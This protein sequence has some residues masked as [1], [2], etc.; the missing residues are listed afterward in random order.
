MRLAV[1]GFGLS[2]SV[3]HG[4]LITACPD[5]ELSAIVTGN[6][7][8]QQ[9]AR[10]SYPDVPV[11]PTIDELLQR[12]DEFDVLVVATTNALHVPLSIQA[13]D[14][15]LH[16]I[17]E[18][19]MAGTRAEAESIFEHADSVGRQVHVFQNRR[20]DSDFLT[21]QRILAAGE[22]GRVHRFQSA[23][24]R[25]RPETQQRWRDIGSADELPGLLYD[26]GS[27]LA[28]QAL[29]LFGPAERVYASARALRAP[30]LA[31]DDTLITIEHTSGVISELAVSALAAHLAPRFRVLGNEAAI[32]ID[33][34][35]EQ[36]SALRDGNVPTDDTWG[37]TQRTVRFHRGDGE[38]QA[39]PLDRGRWDV[40]YPAVAS[41]IAGIGAPPVSPE[42]AIATI[43]LLEQAATSAQSQQWV[44]CS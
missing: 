27:H 41:S 22:L 43:T 6:P 13:L 9:Q 23:F 44:R 1:V 34:L 31:N 42:S 17:V 5:A 32:T 38:V 39:H 14:R 35:D 15:G 20:W 7:E 19:P 37:T 26:L 11:I 18:K 10:D 29:I 25:F 33:G 36:E 40:F 30:R 4:P 24:E 3:F 16:V 2:G 28:D 8:R 21:V 12:S